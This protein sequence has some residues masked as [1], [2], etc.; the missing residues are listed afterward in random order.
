MAWVEELDVRLSA[1]QIDDDKDWKGRRIRNLGAPAE[2]NDALRKAEL[3][4]HAAEVETHG[5]PSGGRLLH[6]GDLGM[7]DGKVPTLPAAQPGQV[8]MRGENGW[9]AG[10]PIRALIASDE[11]EVSESSA[12]YVTKKWL[13]FV[14]YSPL[15]LDWKKLIYVAEIRSGSAGDTTTLGV[16]VGGEERSTKSTT[17]GSYV[18]VGDEI[19]VSDLPDGLTPVEF[20]LKVSAGTG[21]LRTVE[22]WVQ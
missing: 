12:E 3:D 18:L 2:A 8:L 1:I 14:K 4:A 22:V 9:T 17:S 19:D 21:Y 13:N 7:Q 16:F 6:T 5:A 11:S 15:K 10:N 20:K